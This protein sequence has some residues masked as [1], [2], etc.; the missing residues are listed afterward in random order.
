MQMTRHTGALAL[1]L[2]VGLLAAAPAAAQDRVHQQLM[3]EIRMMQEQQQQLQQVIG[4]LA[5]TLGALNAKLDEQGNATR[6]GFA[7]QKLV[8]D[9]MAEGVRILREKADDTGVRLSSLTQ[10]LESLRQALA[11]A[12]VMMPG[13]AG[14]DPDTGAPP[15]TAGAGPPI[16]LSVQRQYD[17]SYGDYVIGQ[18]DLAISGFEEFIRQFP[19]SPLAD[20]AQL[21]IGNS[22]LNSGRYKEAAAAFQRVITDYPNSDN[23]AGAYYKLGEAYRSLNQLGEARKAW[24]AGIQRYPDASESYLARQALERLNRK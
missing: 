17:I 24:E 8:V 6:R 9:N 21:N 12:P 13:A 23:M 7:D 3:A 2:G 5:D 4:R 10:E 15:Q 19:S 18:Y 14:G 16:G 20:D 1:V 22:Y 11:A